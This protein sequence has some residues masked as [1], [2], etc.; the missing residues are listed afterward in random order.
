[1]C[2]TDLHKKMYAAQS[3]IVDLKDESGKKIL[4]LCRLYPFQI[5]MGHLSELKFLGK[6]HRAGSLINYV[7][8]FFHG[9]AYE[10]IQIITLEHFAISLMYKSI[11]NI[12]FLWVAELRERSALLMKG[13]LYVQF[14]WEPWTA[15]YLWQGM[16]SRELK[17]Q[18]TLLLR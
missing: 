12:L 9:L 5:L 3:Q 18:K 15:S 7:I 11:P 14:R 6:G 10:I 16:R 13:N 8:K 4:V 17:T 1:M 2:I